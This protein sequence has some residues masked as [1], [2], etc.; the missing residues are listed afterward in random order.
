MPDAVLLMMELAADGFLQGDWARMWEWARKAL[1]VAVTIDDA[2]T[3]AASTALA[4]V[5]DAFTGMVADAQTHCDEAAALVD[6]LPDEL[7]AQRIDAG[8][9]LMGA[10]LHLSRFAAGRRHGLRTLELGRTTGQGNLLPEPAPRARL[11]LGDARA[12]RRERRAARGRDRGLARVRQPPSPR[13]R[14]DEPV[15]DGE[16][17]RR[18][19]D[20]AGVR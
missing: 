7:L 15:D 13:A 20:G 18:R 3:L 1:A 12:P 19:R 16:R 6:T 9:H 10:E 8:L 14:A 17:G 4:A 5:A 2:P 11:V